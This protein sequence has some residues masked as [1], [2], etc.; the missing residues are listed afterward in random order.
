MHRLVKSL[1]RF[2]RKL[3]PFETRSEETH[4]AVTA[5]KDSRRH[6]RF[7]VSHPDFAFVITSRDD[8]L[9]VAN[10]SFEGFAVFLSGSD[11]EKLVPSGHMKIHVL[12]EETKVFATQAYTDDSIAGYKLVHE[13][14]DS[15]I[16]LRGIIDYLK[17]GTSL[18]FISKEMLREEL[19]HPDWLCLRGE[20]PCDLQIKVNADKEVEQLFLNFRLEENYF[21]IDFKNG[22]IKVGPEKYRT[23]PMDV[24]LK[25][26]LILLLG[27]QQPRIVHCLGTFFRIS[28][29]ALTELRSSPP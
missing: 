28:Q 25:K 5:L 3:L 1:W 24:V 27:V 20:G 9:P 4:F 17:M 7:S 16:F 12:G 21:Q 10:L 15:I 14:S 11:R 26:G 18:Q 29:D 19:R 2:V 6:Q 8:W 22:Q 13:N 23:P